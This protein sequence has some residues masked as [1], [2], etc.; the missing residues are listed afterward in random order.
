LVACRLQVFSDTKQDT[1]AGQSSSSDWGSIQL[2]C[3]FTGK[4]AEKGEP[5]MIGP[6]L[7]VAVQDYVMV[8]SYVIRQPEE[9]IDGNTTLF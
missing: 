7:T 2:V 4:Q 3:L 6:S 1:K 5:V 9:G 8:S